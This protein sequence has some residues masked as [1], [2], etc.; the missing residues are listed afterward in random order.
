M[1]R[2]IAA[3]LF[4][5]SAFAAP[6]YAQEATSEPT[7]VVTETPAPVETPAPPVITVPGTDFSPREIVLTVA[8]GI[9]AVIIAV[10]GATIVQLARNALNTLPPWMIE[11]IRTGAPGALDALDRV[12]NVPGEFDDEVRAKLRKLVYDVLAETNPSMANKVQRPPTI[13]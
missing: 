8:L 5:A 6:A 13:N 10:F 7:P 12:T 11:G 4:A 3:I 1:K 2:T 9:A